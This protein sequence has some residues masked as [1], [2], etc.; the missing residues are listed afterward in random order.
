MKA[1]RRGFTLVEVAVVAVVGALVLGSTLQVLV[2]QQRTFT[3]QNAVISGQQTNRIALDVLFNELREVSAGGDDILAMASDSLRV[4]LMRKFGFVCDT[5]MTGQPSLTV[6]PWGVGVNAFEV[7]DSIFVF[8]DN[9]EG[10]ASD[11]TWFAARVTAVS[12][13]TVCPQD[14]TPAQELTMSG[15][16][17]LFA[18]DSVGIGAPV[19]SF[20]EYTFGT[21]TLLGDT[22]LGRRQGN[23][24]MIPVAGPVR[25]VGGIE[26]VYRDAYGTTTAA[27]SSV[28]QIEVIV[29]TGADVL[30]GRGGLVQDSIT[31]WIYTR[32]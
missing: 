30:N 29:R 27:G 31:A 4:R 20:G 23:G 25:S 9:D 1:D 19:R 8:A 28:R 22:Y 32:N 18:A 11:D 15:Q 10:T 21:T 2:L 6:V 3:A 13:S 26:F 12:N 24:D 5:D 17:A 14:L 7:G 16:G